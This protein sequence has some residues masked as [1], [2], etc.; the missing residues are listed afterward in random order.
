MALSGGAVVCLR[1]GASLGLNVR[2]WYWI[3][4]TN[5]WSVAA[6]DVDGDGKVAEYV[7]ITGG[8]II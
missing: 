1:D 5:I 6:S 8:R 4:S 3:N 7:V 2:T